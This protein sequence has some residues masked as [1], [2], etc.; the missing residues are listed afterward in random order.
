MNMP[1]MHAA[2]CKDAI[3]KSLNSV[4]KAKVVELLQKML[5]KIN[6][7]AIFEIKMLNGSV[8]FLCTWM[9]FSLSFN[10]MVTNYF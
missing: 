7:C 3:I 9:A 8:L 6:T 4:V 5:G 1:W 10:L 2:S